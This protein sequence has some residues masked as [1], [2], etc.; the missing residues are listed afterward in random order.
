MHGFFSCIVKQRGD[1]LLL[2]ET[3]DKKAKRPPSIVDLRTNIDG[4]DPH[5]PIGGKNKKLSEKY[6]LYIYVTRSK[7]TWLHS[8][9]DGE[10]ENCRLKVEMQ[11]AFI[12]YYNKSLHDFIL[13]FG[14]DYEYEYQFKM[15]N[16]KNGSVKEGWK[17]SN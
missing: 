7:H 11:K 15:Q 17:V 8:T 13:I 16:L 1:V 6:G 3:V 2:K 10:I 4:L 5:E 9:E 14:K 12:E